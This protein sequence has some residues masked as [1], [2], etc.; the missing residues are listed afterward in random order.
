M[1]G[2][3][4]GRQ[5]GHLL[6]PWY[7]RREEVIQSSTFTTSTAA[8]AALAGRSAIEWDKNDPQE[9][10]MLPMLRRALALIG[11]RRGSVFELQDIPHDDPPTHDR[12]APG[13]EPAEYPKPQMRAALERTPGGRFFRSR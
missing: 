7:Q 5:L 10:G 9:L 11:A 1:P 3:R 2:P 6:L 8:A 4:F 13:D 12:A